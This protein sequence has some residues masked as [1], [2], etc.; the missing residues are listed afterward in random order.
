MPEKKVLP[1]SASYF[2]LCD[3]ETLKSDTVRAALRG[4]NAFYH[5]LQTF[6]WSV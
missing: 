1:D 6:K 4:T 5:Q 2:E 3:C